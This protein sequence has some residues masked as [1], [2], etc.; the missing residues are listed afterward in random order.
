MA[1]FRELDA[2][3]VPHQERNAQFALKFVNLPP[4]RI[5]RLGQFLGGGAKTAAA[6]HFQEY[7]GGLPVGNDGGARDRPLLFARRLFLLR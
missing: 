4:Q 7:V 6:R 3:H 1:F 2:I 5:D